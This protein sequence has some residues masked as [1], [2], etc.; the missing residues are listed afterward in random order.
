M[1]VLG[2]HAA[3]A[4][5]DPRCQLSLIEASWSLASA[6]VICFLSVRTVHLSSVHRLVH[7]NIDN[8]LNVNI[9]MNTPGIG[10]T[11]RTNGWRSALAYI[12][13]L[14]A[15]IVPMAAK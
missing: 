12:A 15:L 11:W 2:P 7:Q 13:P 8:V 14:A 1:F 3:L 6:V 4:A 5:L 9:T 10:T